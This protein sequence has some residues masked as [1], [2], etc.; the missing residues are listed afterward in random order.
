MRMTP[1]IMFAPDEPVAGDVSAEP[2]AVVDAPVAEPV[3]EA[4]SV[5]D[6]PAAEPAET[7]DARSAALAAVP[8]EH[9]EFVEAQFAA[10]DQWAPYAGL[11]ITDRYDAEQLEA[12]IQLADALQDPDAREDLILQLAETFEVSVPVAEV[13]ATPTEIPELDALRTQ[14]AELQ[15]TV[16]AGRQADQVAVFHKQLQDEYAE[17]EQLHGRAFNEKEEEALGAL[18]EAL[19]ASSD[20]PLKDAY[21]LIAGIAGDAEASFFDQVSGQ[22]AA[23]ESAPGHASTSPPLVDDFA[24]AERLLR[25]RN[26]ASA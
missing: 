7:P 13:I 19:A 20:S 8:D 16:A 5:A 22:P 26:R 18:A 17:V 23:G 4:V 1:R 25:E 3:V 14:L 21:Q 9:R 11:G 10:A 12:V 24:T 2:V 6:T 15:E